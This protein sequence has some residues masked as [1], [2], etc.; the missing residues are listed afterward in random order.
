MRQQTFGV[1]V[2]Y[3]QKL[4]TVSRIGATG[5]GWSGGTVEWWCSNGVAI[6]EA[7]GRSMRRYFYHP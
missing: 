2:G 4:W 5:V 7:V 1:V 3:A 6:E